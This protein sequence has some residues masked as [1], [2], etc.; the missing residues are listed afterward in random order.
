MFAVSFNLGYNFIV[1]LIKGPLIERK[2]SDL[3]QRYGDY[4][5]LTVD[6]ENQMLV[7]GVELHADGEAILLKE[8][9]LFYL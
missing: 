8:E 6:L 4:F 2:I 5:K 3:K 7:A 9:L 1:E